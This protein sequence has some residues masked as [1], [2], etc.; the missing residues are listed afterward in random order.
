M[1]E[2]LLCLFFLLQKPLNI[3]VLQTS[4]LIFPPW[5]SDLILLI[6]HSQNSQ[7][8]PTWRQCFEA[9]FNFFVSRFFYLL[10]S[11]ITSILLLISS[12]HFLKK[13]IFNQ[14]LFGFRKVEQTKKPF[15]SFLFPCETLSFYSLQSCF[16]LLTEPRSN[17][18]SK[19]SLLTPVTKS[20]YG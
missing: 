13:N 10:N 7:Y 16:L 2:F 12:S 6:I 8:C 5:G 15:D 4:H 11:S 1:K 3:A 18:C 14:S 17:S 9:I 20:S 19:L